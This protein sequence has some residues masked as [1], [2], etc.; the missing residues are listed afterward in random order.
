M[1]IISSMEGREGGSVILFF[2]LLQRIGSTDKREGALSLSKGD[3]G[4]YAWCLGAGESEQQDSVR[5]SRLPLQIRKREKHSRG[6]D[7]G[8]QEESAM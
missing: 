6:R 5:S 4:V 1:G 3:I 7:T 2:L 8:K